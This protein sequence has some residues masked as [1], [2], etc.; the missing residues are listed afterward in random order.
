MLPRFDKCGGASGR[1]AD[2]GK[3][4]RPRSRVRS[5]LVRR[6][7]VL[8]IVAVAGVIAFGRPRDARPQPGDPEP[9]P[10]RMSSTAWPQPAAGPSASGDPELLL[11]FDDG[12]SQ[13]TTG[14]VLDILARY[15]VHAVFFV[16]G[17]RFEHGD[18]VTATAL[19]ARMLREGHVIGNHT[20]DHRHLC[21]LDADLRTHEIL[22]ARAILERVS[23]V[24]V[25]WF[26]AP[27][28]ERCPE[29]ETELARLGLAHF[30]WDIDPQEWRNRGPR[31][32][33]AKVIRKLTYLRGR[34]V[35]IM[36]DTKPNTIVALPA[37]LDWIAVENR[38]RQKLGQ[39]PIRMISGR[40][41][42]TEQ[43]VPVVDWL[44]AAG[45]AL[46]TELHA[47]LR[48]ALP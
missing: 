40:Q 5:K 15:D 28:G 13:F 17:W 41:L 29:L 34:A 21:D 2:E 35:L 39:R 1:A 38:R 24:P 22:G 9:A 32:I 48:A 45:T 11:T 6:R 42:A 27:Y 16:Q 23:G 25:P 47:G 30:H 33:V 8:S 14:K 37:I 26:R 19:V 20:I 12:P 18:P 4:A 36:H 3:N 46:A 43:L 10:E 31:F 7:P 44:A